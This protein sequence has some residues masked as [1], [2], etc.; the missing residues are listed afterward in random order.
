MKEDRAYVRLY[1][2]SNGLILLI[3]ISLFLQTLKGR[4]WVLEPIRQQ[5]LFLTSLE[6]EQASAWLPPHT[7]EG[8]SYSTLP[9][10]TKSHID[11]AI[12]NI[13]TEVGALKNAGRQT[14][15]AVEY[16]M[17]QSNR[18]AFNIT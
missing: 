8:S 15:R 4:L 3:F 11:I 1:L 16:S 6:L 10:I 18:T 14:Q 2:Y 5:V 9:G 12:R 7:A 17:S 13:R